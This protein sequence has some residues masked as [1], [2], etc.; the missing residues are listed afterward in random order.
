[1]DTIE[2]SLKNS[3]KIKFKGEQKYTET[4][5][6]ITGEF[7][8]TIYQAETGQW[9]AAFREAGEPLWDQ[10]FAAATKNELISKMRDTLESPVV[11]M[12]TRASE[13]GF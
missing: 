10:H 3:E 1:M 6:L 13:A 11:T 4:K 8:L 7:E 12:A 5:D 2:I 9:I